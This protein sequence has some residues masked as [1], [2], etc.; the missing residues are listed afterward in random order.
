MQRDAELTLKT[1]F[2]YSVND[3]AK[4]AQSKKL[5]CLYVVNSLFKVYFKV[6]P[7]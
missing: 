2:R 7:G 4:L 1:G 3:R 5:G 6:G